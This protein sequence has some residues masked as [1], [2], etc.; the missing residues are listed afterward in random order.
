MRYQNLKK[1]FGTVL[2]IGLASCILLG[3]CGK[4]TETKICQTDTA[5]S[6]NQ[7]TQ[8]EHKENDL[9]YPITIRVGYSTTEE[10]PRGIALKSFKKRVEEK[11]NGDILIDIYP[12][13]KLGSD[14]QLIAGMITGDVDM[15]V[16]SAGNYAAYATRVGVSALPFLFQDFDTAWAFVDSDTMQEVNADLEEYNMHVLA[17]FDNGFRCVTT[18]ERVGAVEEVADMEGLNIRTPDN[19]IVM[20]TMS[21]LGA[22]PRSFPFADLKPALQA[23]EFDAQENPIPVI[24]NNQLYEV[25]KYLSIT[26]HSYDAMPLTIRNDIWTKLP[27]HYQDILLIAAHEAQTENRML[28]KQQT[29]SYVALL[30]EAGMEVTYPNLQPF[31]EATTGV[32]DMFHDVYGEELLK[33]VRRAL[34]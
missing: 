14:A 21:E 33:E 31:K 32:M 1:R 4:E 34:K 13:G 28:V 29:E 7:V 3:G 27:E 19:Q 22:N 20:E 26:N 2:T 15:T 25:Q 16:S 11:T 30:K 12:G 5:E 18:S 23:G 9:T 8:Q 6:Q 10:D 24:Y 17:Y